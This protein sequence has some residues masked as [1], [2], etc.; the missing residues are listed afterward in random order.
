MKSLKSLILPEGN[1]YFAIGPFCFFDSKYYSYLKQRRKSPYDG[2]V[3][4][5]GFN[6]KKSFPLSPTTYMNIEILIS[7]ENEKTI[8]QVKYT[9][10]KLESILLAIGVFIF[11]FFAISTGLIAETILGFLL[12]LV[13]IFL[14]TIIFNQKRIKNKITTA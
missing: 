5:T 7:T 14:Y 10:D 12:T 3:N 11:V 13:P 4:P 9:L 2:K 1:K 6:F 8:I